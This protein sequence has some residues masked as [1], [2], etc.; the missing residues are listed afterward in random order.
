MSSTQESTP[1]LFI[2]S[3][4][5]GKKYSEALHENLDD[6]IEVQPWTTGVFN[7][8][9]S[10]LES[11]TNT[12][13]TIDF[14]VFVFSPDDEGVQRNEKKTFVR[15][16]VIFELGLF[17]GAI[18]RKRCFIIKPKDIDL[19]TPSDLSGIN[20]AQFPNSRSDNNL[21]AALIPTSNKIK[22]IISTLGLRD[23]NTSSI[24]QYDETLKLNEQQIK[25]LY[26]IHDKQKSNADGVHYE[27]LKDLDIP[28]LSI[29]ATYLTRLGL[30]KDNLVNCG[31]HEIN[32]RY[33]QYTEEGENWLL[34]NQNRVFD[35]LNKRAPIDEFNDDD[36]P[37]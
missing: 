22:R 28:G 30:I 33:Y 3:S 13:K 7:L 18:G 10:F 34:A 20:V 21:T 6:Q 31:D 4:T 11:L 37:F 19:H 35:I 1:R 9:E 14:A 26:H 2:G 25:I 5:E 17:L 36:I 16:N 29:M 24:H 32:L 12:I 27:D 15:D 23:K 8:S